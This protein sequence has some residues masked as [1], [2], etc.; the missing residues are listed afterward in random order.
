MFVTS[1]EIGPAT[2]SADL[3]VDKHPKTTAFTP[4]VTSHGAGVL[5]AFSFR[6]PQGPGRFSQLLH[7][8]LSWAWVGAPHIGQRR[9][10]SAAL[11]LE[12]YFGLRIWVSRA[13]LQGEQ[14]CSPKHTEASEFTACALQ[15]Q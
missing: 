3:L 5:L 4:T 11:V 2:L 10:L 13:S 12:A 8:A 9:G 6:V 15:G 7:G 1:T 14:L